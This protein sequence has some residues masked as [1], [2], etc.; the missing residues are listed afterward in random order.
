MVVRQGPDHGDGGDTVREGKERG[1]ILEKHHRLPG[2]VARGRNVV[3]TEDDGVLGCGIDVGIL[4]QPQ[5]ELG[6]QHPADRPVQHRL[7]DDVGSNEVG[8]VL[9]ID[10]APRVHVDGG[11]ECQ[12]GGV[13]PVGCVAVLD[14]LSDRIPVA[15]DEA[16]ELPLT[17]QDAVDRECVCRRRHA[18]QQVERAHDGR[19]AGI[20]ARLEWRQVDLPQAS[21]GHVD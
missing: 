19:C 20:D 10:T 7:R 14:E 16:V 17:A 6:A 18:V 1:V 21:L 13:P 9:C 8:Q 3:V 11:V 4:E 2:G 15:H 12:L 5:H